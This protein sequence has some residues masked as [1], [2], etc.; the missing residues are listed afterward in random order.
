MSYRIDPSCSLAIE[1]L[2]ARI[3]PA[4]FVV[5]SLND[6]G[7]GSLRDAITQANDHAGADT[8]IFAED[9]R[10]KITLTSGQIQITDTLTIRGP[11][12]GA[13]TLDGNLQ[14]RIFSVTD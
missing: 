2:E 8:I 4:T 14:S 7:A 11:G 6:S 13:L 9:I 5:T 10:G 3:A 12:A 1:S